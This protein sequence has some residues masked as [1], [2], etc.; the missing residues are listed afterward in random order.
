[1]LACFLNDI[2]IFV[3]R[4]RKPSIQCSLVAP[5]QSKRTFF[6][7]LSITRCDISNYPFAQTKE[8]KTPIMQLRRNKRKGTTVF[9]FPLTPPTQRVLSWRCKQSETFFFTSIKLGI[10]TGRVKRSFLRR[11]DVP[12]DDTRR[13]FCCFS[14]PSLFR[15]FSFIFPSA[16]LFV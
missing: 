2:L 10:G 1:M 3:F 8:Q 9:C 16:K 11:T 6:N 14:L 5:F 4:S 13:E 12:E 7:C 15:H